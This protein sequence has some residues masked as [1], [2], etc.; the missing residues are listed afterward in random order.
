VSTVSTAS[1]V[2]DARTTDKNCHSF[3]FG[4]FVMLFL[5]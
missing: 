2:Y 4:I 3:G 1:I 5:I